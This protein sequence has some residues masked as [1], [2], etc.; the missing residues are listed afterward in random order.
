MNIMYE[1]GRLVAI[2]LPIA[3]GYY[4]YKYVSEKKEKCPK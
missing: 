3:G 1:F 4:L 2:I